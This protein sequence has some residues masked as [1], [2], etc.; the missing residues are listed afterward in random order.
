MLRDDTDRQIVACLVA[1]G[2]ATFAEIGGVVGLSAPAAKRRV[3]RLVADG[4]IRGFTTVVDPVAFGSSL[5]AFVELHCQ[6]SISP[7]AIRDLVRP[8]SAIVAAYTVSGD[9]DALLHVR[10]ADVAALENTLEDI[11]HNEMVARTTTVIVLSRLL[12]RPQ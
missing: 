6:G 1:N 2:R 3:D 12:E 7:E 4:T 11:R 9:A 8:H 10:C 5:E